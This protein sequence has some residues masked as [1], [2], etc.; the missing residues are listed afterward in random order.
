MQ[1]EQFQSKLDSELHVWLID[2]KPKNLSE[3]ARLADQYVAVRK[4]GSKFNH[5]EKHMALGLCFHCNK[6]GHIMSACPKLRAER[7]QKDARC[8]WSL[9][10]SLKSLK[11]S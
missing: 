7:E 9:L 6:H 4:A 10:C 11:V 5:R 3:A 2:E 8:N 1:R